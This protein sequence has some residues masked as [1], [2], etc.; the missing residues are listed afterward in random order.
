L[1]YR[2]DSSD[3]SN[4]TSNI[5]ISISEKFVNSNGSKNRKR[6]KKE[7]LKLS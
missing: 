5:L 2:L 3:I 6:N 1:V 7:N 4:D